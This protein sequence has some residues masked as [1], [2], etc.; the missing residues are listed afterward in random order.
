VFRKLRHLT[1]YRGR[2][3]WLLLYGSKWVSAGALIFDEDGRLLLIKHRWRGGW[4]YPVGATDGT[5]SPLDAARREVHEEVGLSLG[6]YQLV[7]VDFFHHHTP[8]GNLTFTF[9][10]TVTQAEIANLKLEAFEA[11]EHRWVTPDEAEQLI[12]DHLKSRLVTMLAAYRSGKPV[13]LQSGKVVE[14]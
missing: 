6:N 3:L 5:E 2:N 9:S 7:G 12:S 14:K 11:T 8:N 10:A 13:Y 1:R 4:E